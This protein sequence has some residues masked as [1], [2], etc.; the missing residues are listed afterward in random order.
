MQNVVTLNTCCDIACPTFQLRHIITTGSFQSHR[1]QPTTGSLQI[2]QRF[3]FSQIKKLLHLR[4]HF[5]GVVVVTSSSVAER[6]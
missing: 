3:I 4:L 5:S 6:S 2:R 1:R